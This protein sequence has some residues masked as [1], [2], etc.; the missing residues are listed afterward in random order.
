MGKANDLNLTQTGI[1]SAS[2]TGTFTGRTLT[3]GTNST[4]TNGDGTAGNPTVAAG[5]LVY[6]SSVTA[7]TS[8]TL[9]FTSSIDSTYYAYYFV[10]NQIKM[11]SANEAP[12]VRFSTDGGSTWKT[13]NY[14]DQ[15]TGGGNNGFQNSGSSSRD[16]MN[17]GLGGNSL[18]AASWVTGYLVLTNPSQNL[19]P[20]IY[21]DT[22]IFDPAA[23]QIQF[24]TR[25]AGVYQANSVVN[26]VRF[27]GASGGN[28]TSGT[29]KMYGMCTPS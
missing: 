9:D 5:P 2:G 26:A 27:L 17:M 22:L 3:A 21:G 24:N 23:N 16:R 11:A 8:A 13:A 25:F 12:A 18:A 15:A 4:V 1:I 28:F 20:M 7:S 10:M 19:Y 6:L 29:I 14:S